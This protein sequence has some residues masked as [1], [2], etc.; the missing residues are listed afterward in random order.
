MSN[1]SLDFFGEKIDIAMPNN[2]IDLRK[3]IQE[4]FLFTKEESEEI[5]IK[6]IE[7]LKENI[8]SNEKDYLYF[9]E[10]N[11]RNIFL[12]INETSTVYIEKLNKS[13][14]KNQYT[15]LEKLTKEKED[16][17][18]KNNKEMIIGKNQ[19]IEIKNKINDLNSEFIKLKVK[20]D[21]V[22]NR[23]SHLKS[24]KENEI[25]ELREKL[26]LPKEDKSSLKKINIINNDDNI[27]NQIKEYT[28]E[29]GKKI[30][31][32]YKDYNKRIKSEDYYYKKGKLIENIKKYIY[33][34]SKKNSNEII[35]NIFLKNNPNKKNIQ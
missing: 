11:I 15:L 26:H 28:K 35:D 30:L 5:I 10:T 8:I 1:I 20:L 6:Y 9:K 21:D 23:S 32:L 2:L 29:F 24:K 7:N 17:I 14:I 34:L 22:Y 16:I 18:E 25:N 19:L 4:K 31:D 13:K 3:D 33:N 27:N 12:D